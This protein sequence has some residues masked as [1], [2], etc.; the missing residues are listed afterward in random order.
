MKLKIRT[1]LILAFTTLTFLSG[2]IFLIGNSNAGDLNNWVN[3]IIEVHARRLVL[4]TKI[5]EDIQFITRT[6]KDWALNSDATLLADLVKKSDDRKAQLETRLEELKGMSDEKGAEILEGF[7][8]KWKDYLVVNERIKHLGVDVKTDS[9]NAAAVVLSMNE[10]TQTSQEAIALINKIVQKNEKELD[11]I[12]AE[13]EEKY[14][15]GQTNM[16]IVMA[17]IVALSFAISLWIIS[18]IA[19]S[20]EKARN[21]LKAVSEG[22]L[23]V[24]IENTSND[25][26]GDL[27]DQLRISVDRIKEVISFVV[28]AAENI[29]SASQQMSSSSQQMSQGSTEQAASAEEVSSSMEEMVSNIQQ[30]TDNSQQTEKIALKASD[31]ISQGSIAVNQTVT[32]MKEIAGKVTII[33]E[34]ARQTNLLAL[35]AAVEAARAGEQG[36]GFAVVAAE[37]RKLAER[38]QFA[39]NEINNL[40]ASS[41]SVA[42]KSGKLLMEIV[43]DIQKTAR[44]VQEISAASIEQNTGADQV[45]NAIQQ[46]NQ[47]IQ[48]NAATAEEMAASSEELASQAEQL[49]QTISFFKIER[50]HVQTTAKKAVRHNNPGKAVFTNLPEK[51]K[52]NATGGFNLNLKKNGKDMMDDEFE[53]II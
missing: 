16:M 37:V 42:E 48:Q 51:N 6:E 50:T 27:V 47:V 35:N 3:K 1:R 38:S 31:D 40:S 13:T 44:L 24:K 5:A 12:K 7:S 8:Q 25:E 23:T 36:K 17:A 20:I 41:V 34:I 49:Q 29:A 33:E 39:A 26:I 46:L 43:P 19:S 28:N 9:A 53:K 10:G 18:S 45:N 21:S 15:S 30:N 14:K 22:D 11:R 32:S 52:T 2:V 4:S